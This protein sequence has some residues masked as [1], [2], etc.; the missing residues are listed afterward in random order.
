MVGARLATLRDGQRKDR[1]GASNEAPTQK[2]AATLVNASRASIQRAR[3]VIDS[4]A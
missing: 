2:E 1:Q 3:E 4:E